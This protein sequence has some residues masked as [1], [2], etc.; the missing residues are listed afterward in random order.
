M[1]VATAGCAGD[2]QRALP[3]RLDLDGN[4]ARRLVASVAA[5]QHRLEDTVA[6]LT[7]AE[8]RAA[9]AL[10]GWSAAQLVAHVAYGAAAARRTTSAARHGVHVPFYPGGATQREATIDR[11]LHLPPDALRAELTRADAELVALWSEFAVAEWEI[12]LRDERFPGAVIARHLVLRWTEVEVHRT[13]LLGGAQPWE[14]WSAPFVET[15]L[16][17]RFAWQPL[18][19]ARC[20]DRADGRWAFRVPALATRW[21]VDARDGTARVVAS[22]ELDADVEL[23]GTP[24]RVLALLLG[25]ATCSDLSV[26]G[27]AE[28]AH[29]YKVA[30]PGP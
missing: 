19:H 13:D 12:A 24:A 7:D 28:L 21:V 6:A 30:F 5:A 15:A 16:P 1:T 22:D 27:N 9:T 14:D 4:R 2:R 18:A 26:T 17:L 11:G 10:A 3:V 29:G 25:R 23:S 20:R 8:L